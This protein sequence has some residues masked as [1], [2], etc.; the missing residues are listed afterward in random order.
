MVG[1]KEEKGK[2]WPKSLWVGLAVVVLVVAVVAVMTLKPKIVDK[3]C[4]TRLCNGLGKDTACVEIFNDRI[5]C[6]MNYARF[7]R[8]WMNE[9]FD[10]QITDKTAACSVAETQTLGKDEA[11]AIA[12]ASATCMEAGPV[13]EQG[14]YHAE[15][16][17]WHFE[18][19]KVDA[20]CSY[21]CKVSEV[22][23]SAEPMKVC[24][25]EEVAG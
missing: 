12:S 2:A 18:I 17:E 1:E 6:S 21:F 11:F 14:L 20:N 8:P 24:R 15:S 7:G 3:S 9:L 5:T 25:N 19:N 16:G 22:L 4:C 23:K 13:T 10:F